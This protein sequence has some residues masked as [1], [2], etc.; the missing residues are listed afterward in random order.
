M[1]PHIPPGALQAVRISS[2]VLIW[3]A[4]HPAAVRTRTLLTTAGGVIV[5]SAA[6]AAAG[7]PAVVW[8]IPAGLLLAVLVAWAAGWQRLRKLGP[9][10]IWIAPMQGASF[11]SVQVAQEHQRALIEELRSHD[12]LQTR[13]QFRPLWSSIS[14]DQ[15]ERI[16]EAS[17]AAAIVTGTLRVAGGEARYAA[18]VAVRWATTEATY[19]HTDESGRFQEVTPPSVFRQESM[20][21]D[22]GQPLTQL[23][24]RRFEAPHVTAVAGTLCAAL[25]SYLSLPSVQQKEASADLLAEADNLRSEIGLRARAASEIARSNLSDDTLSE[26]LARLEVAG[27]SDAGHA[28][29]WGH[30]AGIAFAASRAKEITAGR[31]LAVARRY[32]HAA[33]N[34]PEAYYGLGNAY[35][36]AGRRYEAIAAYDQGLALE[37]EYL[38]KPLRLAKGSVLHNLG[39]MDD[40][41]SELERALPLA[42]AYY[43]LGV[44]A[45]DGQRYDEAQSMFLRTLRQDIFYPQ[46][47]SGYHTS[48]NLAS[49]PYNP[50]W[51]YLLA[52][53]VARITA[54]PKMRL[55]RSVALKLVRGFA[56]RHPQDPSLPGY[57]AWLGLATCDWDLGHTAGVCHFSNVEEPDPQVVLIYLMSGMFQV[58]FEMYGWTE[59]LDHF[60]ASAPDI[61]DRFIA[62]LADAPYLCEHPAF[63]EVWAMSNDYF[64]P[65]LAERL[66]LNP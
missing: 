14:A 57:F 37:T 58:G 59:M 4:S 20:P 2:K 39:R 66:N 22:A 21:I 25:A 18:E 51:W 16:L 38:E 65:A 55:T 33:S 6:A 9:G 43:Y 24:A 62:I 32:A 10:T 11:D 52:M 47:L 36:A 23:T 28:D 1:V 60:A 26:S 7:V 34:R 44:V 42:S 41:T 45:F 15:A 49:L 31:R 3:V 30:A 5:G 50:P 48:R 46:G 56:R 53:R 17:A 29:L 13:Y 19:G 12:A 35:S 40:A 61:M 64:G 8:M 54:T 63:P 27:T